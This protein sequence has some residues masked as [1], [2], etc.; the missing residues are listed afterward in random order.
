[1]D[2]RDKVEIEGYICGVSF[3]KG[4]NRDQWYHLYQDTYFSIRA[5]VFPY[6]I[7]EPFTLLNSD[8]TWIPELET[9]EEFEQKNTGRYGKDW[10]YLLEVHKA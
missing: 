4:V 5:G 8:L 3:P 1:M 6:F 7:S 10:R 9:Y 2:Y